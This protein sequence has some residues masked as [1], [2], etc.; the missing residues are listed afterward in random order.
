MTFMPFFSNGARACGTPFTPW[1]Q[2]CSPTSASQGCRGGLPSGPLPDLRTVQTLGVPSGPGSRIG[3]AVWASVPRSTLPPPR[4]RCKPRG[5][6]YGRASPGPYPFSPPVEEPATV[7]PA[8]SSWPRR[9]SR[10]RPLGAPP[11]VARGFPS[12]SSSQ[13]ERGDHWGGRTWRASE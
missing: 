12:S 1:R 10:A 5:A 11:V 2:G 3:E 6:C 8:R 7:P 13:D 9:P 4:H